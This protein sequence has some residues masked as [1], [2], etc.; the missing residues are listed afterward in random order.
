MNIFS[1]IFFVAGFIAGM[2]YY[3]LMMCPREHKHTFDIKDVCNL[4]TDPKCTCG[5]TLSELTPTSKL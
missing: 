1:L 4:D 3:A 5:K 2:F